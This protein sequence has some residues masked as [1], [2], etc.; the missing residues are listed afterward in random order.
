MLGTLDNNNK[1]ITSTYTGLTDAL[2]SI[3]LKAEDDHIKQTAQSEM[4]QSMNDIANSGDYSLAEGKLN[5]MMRNFNNNE[6]LKSSYK[7]GKEY[8]ANREMVKQLYYKGGPDAISKEQYDHYYNQGYVPTTPDDNG[9]FNDEYKEFKMPAKGFDVETYLQNIYKTIPPETFTL[10]PEEISYT[11]KEVYDK[12]G[13]KLPGNDTDVSPYLKRS[14]YGVVTQIRADKINK[15]MSAAL[16]GNDDAKGFIKDIAS[17]RGVDYNDIIKGYVD[18]FKEYAVNNISKTYQQGDSNLLRASKLEMMR[19][20]YKTD[21]QDIDNRDAYGD[22]IV[23]STTDVGTPMTTEALGYTEP[24]IPFVSSGEN[25]RIAEDINDKNYLFQWD[26]DQQVLAQTG[27]IKGINELSPEDQV[28]LKKQYASNFNTN[29][30]VSKELI[31]GAPI[32]ADNIERAKRKDDLKVTFFGED[33]AKGGLDFT[34][35][36]NITFNGT[37]ISHGLYDENFNFLGTGDKLLENLQKVD[38]IKGSKVS[39]DLVSKLPVVTP[40]VERSNNLQLSNA[41][42]VNIGGKTYYMPDSYFNSNNDFMKSAINNIYTVIK[43][44]SAKNIAAFNYN[45]PEGNVGFVI[46]KVDDPESVTQMFKIKSPILGDT[47]M[48]TDTPEIDLREM[49]SK[50]FNRNN[51]PKAETQVSYTDFP[52]INPYN[53]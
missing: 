47:E 52:A 18:P 23:I 2:S 3:D 50:F 31:V 51:P 39:V 28:K 7:R 14:E 12:Y 36:N 26:L 4:E 34:K 6:A 5:R 32:K 29:V 15:I 38:G 33:V 8:D 45:T 11:N 49:Y 42:V 24:S 20:G 25:Q 9:R 17:I 46:S 53:N 1:R 40:A 19:Q 21:K 37:I 35:G 41:Y 30:P 44:G 13:I 16:E 48:I 10:T 27:G 22:P 43:P